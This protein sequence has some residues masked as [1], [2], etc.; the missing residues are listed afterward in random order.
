M[1][2]L[3]IPFLRDDQSTASPKKSLTRKRHF[4]TQ[5][6]DSK[7]C[8]WS[9]RLGAQISK[10]SLRLLGDILE[11][12]K[13]NEQ[14]QLQT[15][16]LGNFIEITTAV[17]M[18]NYRPVNIPP[19]VAFDNKQTLMDFQLCVGDLNLF[20]RVHFELKP[21]KSR[22]GS[23][24]KLSDQALL[25]V[26]MCLDVSDL[27]NAAEAFRITSKITMQTEQSPMAV[28][29]VTNNV[30]MIFRDFQ[31]EKGPELQS[32]VSGSCDQKDQNVP[33]ILSWN[34][35]APE[36][37]IRSMPLFS[38]FV[39]NYN[40]V[41][42]PCRVVAGSL[43]SLD[44]IL[45][46]SS[47]HCIT[48]L[49]DVVYSMRDLPHASLDPIDE[50]LTAIEYTQLSSRADKS[51]ELWDG[52]HVSIAIG[53]L[54]LI[55]PNENLPQMLASGQLENMTTA[56][57]VIESAT[58]S[59]TVW[60]TIRLDGLGYPPFNAT[61]LPRQPK[62]Q[63]N[64][65]G[66]ADLRIGC[67][68]GKIYGFI[69]GIESH[70]APSLMGPFEQKILKA[71]LYPNKPCTP[72]TFMSP[73]NVSLNVLDAAPKKSRIIISLTRLRVELSKA[74]FDLL[75][76]RT[77]GVITTVSELS[78]LMASSTA[79]NV[80]T[81]YAPGEIESQTHGFMNDLTWD[82]IEMAI[83][84]PKA[85]IHL[86]VGTINLAHDTTDRSGGCS[87]QNAVVGFR[88]T[89]MHGISP[90]EEVV[91]GAFGD[92]A[93]WQFGVEDYPEKLISGRW[94]FAKPSQ[95]ESTL[96]LDIQAY[97]LHVSGHFL[98][99]L[100]TMLQYSHTP[101]FLCRD[102]SW[103]Q[104]RS[105]SVRRPQYTFVKK[106]T[107]KILIAPSVVSF[108]E[109]NNSE[110][111]S[112][113]VWI[114]FG[115]LFASIGFGYD[116]AE[117]LQIL[118][119]FRGEVNALNRYVNIRALQFMLNAEKIEIK[120]STQAP[121]LQSSLRNERFG[122]IS[123]TWILFSN[124][125]TAESAKQQVV[126]EFSMRL[127]G[128][129][130][131]VLERRR[132][133]HFMEFLPTSLTHFNVQGELTNVGVKISSYS[134]ESV[135][136]LVEKVR[137][138]QSRGSD[139][140][141]GT[142][143]ESNSAKLKVATLQSDVSTDDFA[144]LHRMAESSHPSPGELV[145]SEVL[146]IET[147]GSLS[148][149]VPTT[150]INTLCE[151]D[152]DQ[153]SQDEL[154]SFIRET[155]SVWFS[156]DQERPTGFSDTQMAENVTH[157]WMTMRWCYHLPRAI[158]EIVSNPVPLPPSGIP[159]GWPIWYD[160]ED[161]NQVQGRICDILCQLRCWNYKKARFVVVG[162]FYVPWERS[163][164]RKVP[165]EYELG[166]FGELVSQW[167]EGDMDDDLRQTHLLEFASVSRTTTFEDL[168]PSDKWELRWRSPLCSEQESEVNIL[169]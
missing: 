21:S 129:Q 73:F 101:T 75:A 61:M 90:I 93:L 29:H 108:W 66:N 136:A 126:E 42:H 26:L 154:L 124:V 120:S 91:F 165:N 125:L 67:R 122:T 135:L 102:L 99:S 142:V 158:Q 100:A 49:A 143:H 116:E 81:H 69:A 109:R 30:A 17:R 51:G 119:G 112:T 115:Q 167:F 12:T 56:Y 151:V 141:F 79:T 62:G 15:S 76:R 37:P 111:L 92:P 77:I 3:K 89:I 150:I 68:L 103:K 153:V 121:V 104:N 27:T 149:I 131:L 47:L 46:T 55:L 166:S 97:Q 128:D 36:T 78:K 84:S 57:F 113:N 34:S 72:V 155:N 139:S 18:G 60:N 118:N 105:I 52:V 159:N 41:G 160:S 50:E 98:E 147:I 87:I 8:K 54:R 4:R 169:S 70:N 162:E 16:V 25:R 64:R 152:N 134:L 161:I 96:F 94:S 83:S 11:S 71:S 114:P 24:L 2:L 88:P 85:S 40:E 130:Q 168:L 138:R 31:A 22:F 132:T 163:T 110:P 144:Y 148:E 146:F 58:I 123:S 106:G 33:I 80:A 63:L 35:V 1:Y 157:S 39:R 65:F 44:I 10:V 95:K 6:F 156:E 59:S 82:G 137:W 117:K 19:S 38:L 86:R 32:D 20:E 13:S 48:S 9:C 23:I 5:D 127:T 14:V 28:W 7:H 133:G 164:Q 45:T 107:V 43:E 53:Q 74:H 140:N 145:F